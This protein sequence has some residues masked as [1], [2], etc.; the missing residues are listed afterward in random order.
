MRCAG[1]EEFAGEPK[2]YE[3]LVTVAANHPPGLHYA[4]SDERHKQQDDVDKKLE[5]GRSRFCTRQQFVPPAIFRDGP[6]MFCEH[7]RGEEGKYRNVTD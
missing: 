6:Q 4:L 3:R 7:G 1:A 2:A 5:A